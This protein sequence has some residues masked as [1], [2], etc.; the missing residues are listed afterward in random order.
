MAP[1]RR[2]PR[3]ARDRIRGGGA[4]HDTSTQVKESEV[5]AGDAREPEP[6][7]AGPLSAP[8]MIDPR[9]PRA[10]GGPLATPSCSNRALPLRREPKIEPKILMSSNADRAR[11]PALEVP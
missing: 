4:A 7:E 1:P 6:R 11:A 3:R 9:G 2:R 5:E 8:G 10:G